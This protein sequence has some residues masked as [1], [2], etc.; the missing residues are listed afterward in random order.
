MHQLT[1][2]FDAIAPK[3]QTKIQQL[4][5]PLSEDLGEALL[6]FSSVNDLSA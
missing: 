6:D 2:R 5:I 4:F 3:L 1:R